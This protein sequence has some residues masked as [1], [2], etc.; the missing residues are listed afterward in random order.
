MTREEVLQIIAEARAKDEGVNLAG[1]TL[2]SA[3]LA[4]AYLLGANLTGAEA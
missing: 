3:N 1:A 4:G 2:G